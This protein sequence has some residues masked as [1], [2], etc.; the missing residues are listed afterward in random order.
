MVAPPGEVG[1][2]VA[3]PSPGQADSIKAIIR[4]ITATTA[5][6]DLPGFS[7]ILSILLFPIPDIRLCLYSL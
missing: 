1:A 2:G 6:M 7:F 5:N 3:G 4:L